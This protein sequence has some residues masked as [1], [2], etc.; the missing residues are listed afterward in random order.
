MNGRMGES[1]KKTGG[2]AD[3]V[4]MCRAHLQIP[5]Q[6]SSTMENTDRLLSSCSTGGLRRTYGFHC[7]RSDRCLRQTFGCFILIYLARRGLA[8]LSYLVSRATESHAKLPHMVSAIIQD[9]SFGDQTCGGSGKFRKSPG[10]LRQPVSEPTIQS[11]LGFVPHDPMRTA[12][13]TS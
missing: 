10:Y 5:R 11:C 1:L 3:G 2:T 13:V 7:S 4:V 8:R 6:A 12:N 9:M